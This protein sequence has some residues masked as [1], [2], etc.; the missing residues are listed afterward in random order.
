MLLQTFQIV[1]FASAV[2]Y[3]ANHRLSSSNVILG[4]K[5]K[6]VRN[7][8]NTKISSLVAN[9]SLQQLFVNVDNAAIRF[10]APGFPLQLRSQVEPLCFFKQVHVA[11]IAILPDT[12]LRSPSTEPVSFGFGVGV[13]KLGE[14]RFFGSACAQ[15]IRFSAFCPHRLTDR[16][17]RIADPWLH[18]QVVHAARLPL[19]VVVVNTLRRNLQCKLRVLSG[20]QFVFTVGLG[21]GKP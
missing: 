6:M 2:K 10:D 19:V 11:F 18:V 3:F 9:H 20:L 13:E 4:F 17:L 5:Y 16:R 21:R 12:G 1:E 7:K 14:C 15:V 8:K